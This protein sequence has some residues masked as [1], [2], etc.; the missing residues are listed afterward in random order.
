MLLKSLRRA[1]LPRRLS[2]RRWFRPLLRCLAAA[3]TGAALSGAA[4]MELPVPLLPAYLCALTFGP[5]AV[6]AYLGAAAGYLLLWET[7]DVLEPLAAGLLILS[8]LGL[9]RDL[10]PDEQRWFRSAAGSALYALVS[11]IFLLQGPMQPFEITFF[12][13]K[14]AV[15]AAFTA[16]FTGPR[17][18]GALTLAWIAGCAKLVFPGDLSLGAV[19][20]AAAVCRALDGTNYLLTAAACGLTLDVCREPL[21]SATFLYTAS[22]L[23]AHAAP[24]R[25]RIGRALLF[26][27]TCAVGVLVGGAQEPGL[28]L[29]ALAGSLL[30]CFLPKETTPEPAEHSASPSAASAVLDELAQLLSRPLPSPSLPDGDTPD[31]RAARQHAA[32]L[33]ETRAIAAEQ[34]RALARL[35]RAEPE[36]VPALDFRPELHTR[37]RG[38]VRGADGDRVTSFRHGE[39]FYLLLCDGMGTGPE[40]AREAE[41]AGGLLRRMIEGGFDAQDALQTLNAL[42]ILRGDGGFSTVDLAQLSLVTGEGFLQKWG[43]APSYL[44]SRLGVEK[45][46]T[47]SPPPGLGVGEAHRAEC[48]RLSMRRGE[49]LVLV[50]DGVS[51]QTALRALR[52]DG[53]PEAIAARIVSRSDAE[54]PDDRSAAVLRLR[55]VPSQRKHITSAARILSN[56]VRVRNI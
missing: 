21:L 26:A 36:D 39:W 27:C 38:W 37:T 2:S 34:Y 10:L 53:S 9:F 41:T 11:L 52:S 24:L 32:R 1:A 15:L 8:G 44:R 48:V 22:A 3:L 30:S 17:R 54:E 47:A 35:L 40:A 55:P 20:A 13:L 5:E 50:S 18:R 28:F 12:F 42:Y 43:A 16:A 31:S 56:L 4:V 45:I 6:A 19:L 25:T 7:A 14:L 49:T 33:S 29:T 51:E 46:G 23:A